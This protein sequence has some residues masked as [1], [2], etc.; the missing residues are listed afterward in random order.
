MTIENNNPGNIRK[1]A[2][3]TWQGEQPGTAPGDFV[4]FD[5]LT[6]GYRAMIKDFQTKISNGYDT[7]SKI[8]TRYAPPEENDTAAYITYVSDDT[9]VDAD[10]TLQADDVD[11]LANI[12]YSMSFFEH[13]IDQDDGTLQSALQAAK[14][15]FQKI[16]ETAKK[17]SR[18]N[19]ADSYDNRSNRL[20]LI[21]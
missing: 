7:L 17:K 21:F 2:S 11:T 1:S 14:N 12:A 3:F 5:T 16:V 8:I 13:G 10:A 9:G 18:R 6:N 20:L 15:L 4:V 19:V